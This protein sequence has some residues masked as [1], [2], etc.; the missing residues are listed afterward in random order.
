M[1]GR[2]GS[3]ELPKRLVN[4]NFGLVTSAK[5]TLRDATQPDKLLQQVMVKVHTVQL[6]NSLPA[7]SIIA[8]T[9]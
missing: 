7:C 8:P 5:K 3:S 6:V 1:W 9:H 2:E 4:Q